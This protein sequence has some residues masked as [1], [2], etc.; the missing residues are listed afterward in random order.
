VSL[1]KTEKVH[2]KVEHEEGTTEGSKLV[3]ITLLYEGIYLKLKW[4]FWLSGKTDAHLFPP[5]A[6]VLIVFMHVVC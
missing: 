6:I 4:F 2:S 1:L 5:T 3:R